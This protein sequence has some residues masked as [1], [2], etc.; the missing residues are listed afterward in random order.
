MLFPVTSICLAAC[1]YAAY[2]YD[3]RRSPL[4]LGLAAW[5]VGIVLASPIVFSYAVTYS[6]ATDFFVAACLS[7]V[8]I[9]YLL[10]RNTPR[11]APQTYFNRPL[12]LRIVKLLGTA[13]ALGCILLLV[14]A[15]LNSGLQLSF[16]Y[17]AK[18]I[19]TIRDQAFDRLA[20]GENRGLIGTIG[21]LLAPCAVLNVIAT[22]SLGRKAGRLFKWLA[23]G[24]FVLIAAVS[25]MVFAGRAIVANVIFL[26]LITIFLQ[27][28]RLA[29]VRARTLVVGVLAFVAI[30]FFSTTFLGSREG[31][32]S[33]IAVLEETQRAQVRP[34]L[35]PLAEDYPGV[36]LA[37]VSAGYFASPIPTLHFYTGAKPLPGPFYGQYTYQL[38]ARLVGTLTGTWER[39]QWLDTRKQIF[40]PLEARNYFGNVWSTWLRDLLVDFGYPGAILFCGLFGMFLAW[41]RNR[42]ELT[43]AQHYAYLQTIAC[44]TLAFGAFT[45]FMWE[46]FLAYPFFMALGIMVITR[47]ARSPKP[48]RAPAAPGR[49]PSVAG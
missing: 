37:A 11:Q 26:V 16:S 28:R 43:G 7:A 24:N 21:G 47:A 1:L 40:A 31:S 44:F 14:D 33:A 39:N 38:P 49:A 2:R 5:A 9:V 29:P 19:S 25:L 30:A 42:W 32:I 34:W 3:G 46:P 12:E 23:V 17:V 8:T 13:G 45:S 22:A 15:K 18:N 36:G 10:R 20:A 35:E 6:L 4:V 41:T 48:S 27:G